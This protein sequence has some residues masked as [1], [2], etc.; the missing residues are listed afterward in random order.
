MLSKVGCSLGRDC[1][2]LMLFMRGKAAGGGA[3][4]EQGFKEIERERKREK[5]HIQ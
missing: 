4:G 3:G 5:V 1:Q 2:Q